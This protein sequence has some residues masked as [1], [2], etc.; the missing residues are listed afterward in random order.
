MLPIQNIQG[1][2]VVVRVDFNVPIDANFQ[3][4]DTTRLEGAVPT[5]TFLLQQGAKVVLLSHLGRPLKKK[6]EDGSLDVEKY[7]LRHVLPYLSKIL[8]Q[9]VDFCPETIGEVALDAIAK[10]QNGGII[11]MENTRFHPGEEKGDPE[12]AKELARLGEFYVNDAFGAAHRRHASTAV[13]AEYYQKENKCLGYLVEQEITNAEKVLKNPQRPFTA[14]MG[15]AKVSD[16]ILLIEK[17]L[18]VAN[19]IIIGG[20]MAYTLIKAM[21]GEIGSSLCEEDKLELAKE[22]IEKAREKGVRLLLPS[23]TLAANAFDNEAERKTV[24]T[25][26]IPQGWMGLDIGPLAT[27]AFKEAILSSKTIVW[28]GPMGVFEM[29]NFS[30][31]TFAIAQALAQATTAGAFTLVGG[32]DSVAAIKQTGLA[33]KVSFVSTGGGALLEFMEG[34]ELPG[35]KAIRE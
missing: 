21:G 10:L 22:L 34:K 1:K 12:Y 23:D 4:T 5:L 26:S 31:G 30:G 25:D 13:I 8:G 28:N 29:S 11:L 18:E 15:G 14:I 20:G 6:K 19:N 9:R 16:K 35:I 3:V 24:D 33:D 27:E 17:L 7:T 32:G 2:N